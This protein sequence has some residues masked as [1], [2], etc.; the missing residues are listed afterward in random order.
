DIQADADH[1]L[2]AA[3]SRPLDRT[4][5]HRQPTPASGFIADAIFDVIVVSLAADMVLEAPQRLRQIVRVNVGRPALQ[6][7]AA[8]A[9]ID[10][11]PGAPVTEPAQALGAEIDLPQSH[12]ARPRRSLQTLLRRLQ[13]QLSALLS[14][15]IERYAYCGSRIAV[16]I[17]FDRA[18]PRQ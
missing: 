3:I 13:F 11:E 17:P 1:A 5:A 7:I 2:R 15:D 18:T 4:T 9:W 8:I 12:A 10:A 6:I 16:E 14:I